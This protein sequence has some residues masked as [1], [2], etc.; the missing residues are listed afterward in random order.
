MKFRELAKNV[1]IR[2]EDILSPVDPE[3]QIR[4]ATF[5]DFIG[6]P[7]VIAQ[8][9]TLCRA[10][11]ERGEPCGHLLMTGPGGIGKSSLARMIAT[12]MNGPIYITT[13]PTLGPE[14]LGRILSAM[15]RNGVL[16]I[17]EI[18]GLSKRTWELLYGAM[19]DGWYDCPTPTG[20]ERRK[21]VPFTLVGT[22]T[23]PGML[24]DSAK[25]RFEHT[26]QI[27]FYGYP[28]MVAILKRSADKL[29]LSISDEGIDT[30]ADRS[31]GVPRIGNKYLR[32]VRDYSSTHDRDP[33]ELDTVEDA[34]T[35]FG[36]DDLG[37][38]S[39][40]REYLRI[41]FKTFGSGPVGVENI[42]VVMGTDKL[43]ISND[44]EPYLMRLG[45]VKRSPRGRVLTEDGR[46]HALD[47]I[48][49]RA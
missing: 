48:E 7:E 15:K 41:L 40:D 16:V 30:I 32:H 47:I 5:S 44:I 25:D 21:C 9:Q 22:T 31:R 35:L 4:P 28:E 12:E 36:V 43:T 17:E 29:G 14:T 24:T 37:L 46:T 27:T 19:E 33:G 42:A 2:A 20:P 26:S 39:D 13:A 49:G 11:K 45:L 38:T 6:Q 3:A 23:D 34:L 8:L 1:A 10:A 18:Q